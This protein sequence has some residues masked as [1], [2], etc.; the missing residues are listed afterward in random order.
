MA[1]QTFPALDQESAQ[2]VLD[3]AKANGRQW[4][5]KLLS[6]WL[7]ARLRGAIHRVRNTHGP[8]WLEKVR[9]EELESAAKG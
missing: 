8:A 1:K 4:K 5:Q 6:D 3:Y 2:A 7:A 9:L